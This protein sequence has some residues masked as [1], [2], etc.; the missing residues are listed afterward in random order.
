M[1]KIITIILLSFFI[2]P[3]AWS[4]GYQLTLATSHIT[5]NTNY[6]IGASEVKSEETRSPMEIKFGK[7]LANNI[8]IGG[9]YDMGTRT[10]ATAS[11]TT[12]EKSSGYG[13]VIGYDTTNYYIHLDYFLSADYDFDNNTVFKEGSGPQI[14]FGIRSKLG[15]GLLVLQI[16]YRSLNY[17]TRDINGTETTIDSSSL[18]GILPMIGYA[19][20]F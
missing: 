7:V 18:G 2:Q 3:F 9:I 16:A 10:V 20:E 12:K 13:I 11:T 19:Y 1:K 15:P 8:F 14:D 6:N 4:S 17:K 5:R